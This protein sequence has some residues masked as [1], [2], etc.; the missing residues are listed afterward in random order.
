MVESHPAHDS[1]RIF[2]GRHREMVELTAALN[3]ALTGHGRLVMLT[4]EPGIGKTRVAQELTGAAESQGMRVFWGRCYEEQGRPPT[5]HGSAGH[6]RPPPG[7]MPI[8]TSRTPPTPTVTRVS[9]ASRTVRRS[10]WVAE[11]SRSRIC[12]LRAFWAFCFAPP[13]TT[14]ASPKPVLSLPKDRPGRAL[15]NVPAARTSLGS[16]DDAPGRSL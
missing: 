6:N 7:G 15:E 2:V 10:P 12:S 8:E 4:G 16:G 5:G 11:S 14:Q 3:D 9:R 1:G 13:M